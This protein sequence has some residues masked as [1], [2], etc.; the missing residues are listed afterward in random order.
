MRR[1]QQNYARFN[2]WLGPQRP[3]IS[4]AGELHINADCTLPTNPRAG[5]P[6]VNDP[7]FATDADR[8]AWIAANPSCTPPPPFLPETPHGTAQITIFEAPADISVS[9][10]GATVPVGSVP[11]TIDNRSA[12]FTSTSVSAG[13]H[14]I[15]LT[16]TGV[17]PIQDVFDIQPGQ[18][19]TLAFSMVPVA[20]PQPVPSPVPNQV[21]SVIVQART[22]VSWGAVFVIGTLAAGLGWLV[23]REM[24]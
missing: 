21:P 20:V 10:D 8:S 17:Q 14:A 19:R 2:G 1:V 23:S 7:H 16:G 15:K 22:G 24:R 11:V 13:R 3:G 9:I 6:G 18:T 5:Q 4:P 12:L